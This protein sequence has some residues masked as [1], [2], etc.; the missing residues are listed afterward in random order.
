MSSKT[1]HGR[2]IFFHLNINSLISK[3]CIICDEFYEKLSIFG[4]N[5]SGIVHDHLPCMLDFGYIL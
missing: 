2:L 1:M 4:G 5:G 3:P